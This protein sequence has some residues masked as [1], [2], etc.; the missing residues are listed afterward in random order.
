MAKY[1]LI[2]NAMAASIEQGIHQPGERLPSVRE[3]A[4]SYQ[5]SKSTIIR[6][7]QEL[8]RLHLI[9]AISQSGF[10]V[11]KRH[12]DMKASGRLGMIDFS[13]ASP[14]PD[15]FPYRDFQIC[16]HDAFD[17]YQSSLFTYG[18]PQGLL[19]LREAGVK[20][21]TRYQLFKQTGDLFITSGIQ[22]ALM[23]LTTMEFPTGRR[24]I[25][26]EQPSYDIYQQYLEL[27]KYPV[28]GLARNENGI[29]LDMLESL[30]KRGDIK[31]FYTMS[32]HHNPLGTSYSSAVRKAIA[33]LADKYRVYV[34]ED[35]YVADLSV[36]ARFD[37]ICSYLQSDY[38]IYLKSFSKITFPGLRVGLVVLPAHLKEQ[39]LLHKRFS[40]LD[41]SM[42]SQAALEV[43]LTNG[44][45]A[46]HREQIVS[47]Y[48]ERIRHVSESVNGREPGI[49]KAL[50]P[51][52][53][54]YSCLL[55]PPSINME[56]LLA[57]LEER[58]IRVAG[59]KQF[60]LDA[61]PE[62]EKFLRLSISR[63]TKEEIDAGMDILFQEIKN[64]YKNQF[65]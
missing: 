65:L 19:S 37:P 48:S 39:F 32:R 60:Y 47:F 11:A 6:A 36:Q 7:Y 31:F 58:K 18:E 64:V 43:Y 38:M 63:T 57:R 59:S 53:G 51:D 30:F 28:A 25:L 52:T 26:I 24:T 20:H 33:Y 45:F 46:R 15:F 49:V 12:A 41:T 27:H 44:M 13:S 23:I 3:A 54:V 56:R 21:L 22:Q 17:K 4:Q 40:D 55:L 9:Y 50:V 1:E 61:Y 10:Y 35:D 42:L 16:V 62:K 29:D 2:V 14:N 34:V 5:C 8:V